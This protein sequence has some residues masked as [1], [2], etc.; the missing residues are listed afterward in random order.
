MYQFS[1]DSL[2]GRSHILC[3]VSDPMEL[4]EHVPV[5]VLE[6]EHLEYHAPSDDDIQV[7]D[8]PHTDDT[9]QTIESPGYI[10]DSYSMGEGDDED[11][12]E[13]PSEEH[14]PEDDDEDP[15]EDP[16]EEHEPED[17]DTKE[18]EPS[19]GS[20]ETEPFKEDETDVIPPPPRHRGARI[21]IIPQTPIAAST[22]ALIDAFAAG[23][24][25]FPLPPTS[26]AYDQAPLGHRTA[27]IR[28]RDDILEE[29]MPPR[30]RFIFTALPPGCDV[31]E[32]SAAARAPRD[33]YDFVDTIEAG[34]G[35]I[36]SLGHDA[37]TIARANDRVEDVG[38]VRALHAIEN[39]MMTSI[40]EVNLRINYQVQVYRQESKALLA[41]LEILETH[42]S[43]MEWQRQSAEDLAVTQMMRIHAL[44]ARTRTDTVDDADS[45]LFLISGCVVDNQGTLKKKLTDKY[46]PK[47]EIKKLEIEL[48]NLR[49][50]GTDAVSY[51]QRFQELALRCTKFLADE[52]EKVDNYISGLPDNIH[53]N[54]MSTIPKTLDETIELAN[55]LMDRKLRTY[56]E[57]QNDNK[58]KADDSS[59][60]KQQQQ[61]HKKQKIAKAY[62]ASPD[63]KRAY[64]RNLPLCTK[65]N[66]HHTKK[67]S[68]N[69]GNY[70]R[71]QYHIERLHSRLFESS[72]QLDL[73]LVP[74]GSFDIVIGMDWLREYHAVNI[75]DEKIVRVPFG[76]ETLIFQGKR[77]DQDVPIVRDFPKVF[78]ED[79]PGIPPARQVEFQIDLVPG[80]VPVARAPYRLAPAEM[81]E[82]A[83]QLQEL[84][85]KGFVRPNSSPWGAP[86]FFVK[87][88]DGLFRMCIDYRKLNKL[89][90]KNRYPI[91]RI[92]D[93]FDQLQ[94]SSVY[95]KIDLRSGYYQLRV[96]EEDIPKTAFRTRYGHYEFQAMPFGLTNAL[97]NK[98]EH[99]ENLKLIL[100]LLKKKELYAKFSIREFWIPKV[101][102]LRHVI[103]SKGIHVDPAKIKSIKDWASP[104]TPTKIRQFLGLADYYWF[105]CRA[106]AKPESY[107]LCFSKTHD[108]E[109]GAVVFALKMWRHYI[110][111]CTIF[112]DRKSL[113]HILDQK[114]LNMRQRRWLELLSDYDCDIHYHP[115]KANVVADDLSRKERSRPLRVRAL[116]MTM[117]MI[118]KDLPKEKLEPHADGTLCLNNRSWVPCFGDLRTLIM[119]E[120]QISKWK[121][122]KITMDFITKLP[123]TTNG[124]D[125]IWV[126]IDRLTKSAHFLPMREND[127]IK[128]LMKLYMK[129][130]VTRH[131]VPVSIISNRDGRF[132]SLF[133]QALHTAF[134]TR[135]DMS[136]AYHP[137]TDSQSEKTI[138]TL[139]GMIQAARDRQKS[140]ADLKRKPMD[141]QVGERVMLKVSP[142]KGVVRFGKRGKLNRRYV[143]PFKVLSKVGDVANRL[144]LSQQLSRVHNTF[145]LHFV[146]EPV[147]IMDRE[148]KQLKR[149][150]IPIIKV[151]DSVALFLRALF[152]LLASYSLLLYFLINILA[153]FLMENPDEAPPDTSVVNT[154]QEPWTLFTDGSSCVDGSGAGLI[155]TSLEETEFTYAL[156]F[157]FASSNNESEYE[158]LIAGL[159]IAT[160]IGVLVEVLKEKSIQENE[161]A[162]MVEEDG[163]TWMTPIMEYLKDGTLPGDRKEVSKLHIKARHYELLE[164]VLYRRSFL[165]PWLRTTVHG[166]QSH[167]VG[168]LLDNHV[169]GCTGY[170][171]QIWS[172]PEW[173]NKGQ[174]F[175]VA[176]DY[177]TKWIEAKSVATTTGS[178]VQKFVWDNIVCR[179]GLPGEIVSNNVKHPQ[180]NELVERANRSLDEGTKACL[181]EGNKNWIEGLPHVLWAYRTMI[182]SRHGYTPFSLTYRT[183]AVIPTKIEMPMYR[184]AIVDACIM[185]KSYE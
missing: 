146:E 119:H 133:W 70:K 141:L 163:P 78:L 93:L 54:I 90:V 67:C 71:S 138:Q 124:Y 47:G 7:E 137:E 2:R 144:E 172:F 12:E 15:E 27:M 51:T 6:P 61:P 65:C 9:S 28:K 145:H 166:G 81:K 32:S 13:D 31:V 147:E 16:N 105:G 33:Q 30:R 149:S 77:N 40:E 113:Q 59:R 80:A 22:H 10:V 183:E 129:K 185:M 86:V 161:V 155:L 88:K 3:Y 19:E 44:E 158:A 8:Q 69:C 45:S 174:V 57:W 11:P 139:K 4:D 118:R 134:G 39:M 131:G 160:Q 162:K 5:Y 102:F 85:D 100:E 110:Y 56:A 72:V 46:C 121:W 182:K 103:N 152:T 92:D 165:K 140:Y 120:S 60:N 128:K 24:P 94:G 14:E 38:Y 122:E 89:T 143:R 74:L 99:E 114:E 101:Q 53:E 83:D 106:Y 123:K 176:M 35:L 130:E 36:R 151:V 79:L 126:I 68:P 117:G 167:A 23:S 142:W 63:E 62:T 52:T 97:T 170:D 108:L 48:W 116:V 156:M 177:F 26:P 66:Y 82:P 107:S 175:I 75:Y 153:D 95:S 29:D 43:H 84:S 91:P 150:R 173:T 1:S 42:M 171:T 64:T 159:W 181:G 34:Q 157:Q 41:R 73:M 125:T 87:K 50:K 21:S 58:R 136:M 169:S 127:P 55:N 25:L 17:E 37:W 178:Q 111:G 20:D 115:G 148:I 98:E 179:F 164:G 168:I 104:K 135:L 76:N 154:P 96:R 18:E 49:I 132:T 109:L 184:T 112:T 180:S